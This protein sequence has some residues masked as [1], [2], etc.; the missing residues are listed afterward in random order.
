M[1]KTEEYRFVCPECAESIAVNEQ[2]KDAIVDHGCVICGT[3]IS[4]DAFS[5]DCPAC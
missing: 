3:Q 1:E 2:M 4:S 5:P